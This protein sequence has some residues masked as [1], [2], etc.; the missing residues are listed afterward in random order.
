MNPDF[1][2]EIPPHWRNERE[3]A[4]SVLFEDWLGATFAVRVVDGLEETRV[5][6]A[7]APEDAMIVIPD[8]LMA[9]SVAFLAPASLPSAPVPSVVLP[10][11][12]GVP[13]WAGLEATLPLL[14]ATGA[15]PDE[16][17]HRDGQRFILS[18]DLLG[19]LLFMLTRYEEHLE[20]G[21]R[22]EHGRFPA[23]ASLLAQS[24]WLQWPML[25]MY[26]HVFAA[27]LRLVWPGLRLA[28]SGYEGLVLSH[29]VDHPS[30]SMR[31]RGR[32][33]LRILA[34]DVG[35]RRDIGLGLRRAGAFIAGPSGVARFD[36]LNTYD[37][38]MRASEHAGVRSTFFFLAR[39]TQIPNGSRYSL[40]DRWARR[41][42]S[43]I[44]GRGHRIGLH[45]SYESFTD[46]DRLKEEWT[47]LED[48]CRGVASGALRRAIRQHYLRWQPGLTWRAQVEAGLSVDETLGFA[49]AIGYRAGTA[50][51][52]TAYDLARHQPL[53]LRV[54]P[55][56]VMD[57]TLVRY[58]ALGSEEAL[59]RVADLGGRTRMFGGGLSIL[60]HNSS[61]ETRPAKELYLRLL[62]ELTA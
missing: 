27:L 39:D 9:R 8:V 53:S 13:G 60:W 12:A 3:Y 1:L 15:G 5:R 30:S 33:R 23:G 10:G 2:I 16:V 55:L 37:F 51:T 41:L 32:Q 57:A 48:A 56:H 61:L 19:S 14:Y 29:D 47:L 25:D 38:L 52:F 6:P 34:G 24:G 11:W 31:W 59:A 50:R 22:D 49:D 17:I 54:R 21:D 18:W 35:R 43:E 4:L 26:L 62:R 28:P 46:P 42:I 7:S 58:M 36:P 45:G 40:G 20:I 44:A